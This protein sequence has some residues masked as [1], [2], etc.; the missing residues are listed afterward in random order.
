MKHLEINLQNGVIIKENYPIAVYSKHKNTLVITNPPQLIAT[1]K[2]VKDQEVINY[3]LD[4]GILSRLTN[5]NVKHAASLNVG[6]MTNGT[7]KMKHV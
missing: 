4:N 3:V 1:D 5:L 7:F 6:Y 2:S